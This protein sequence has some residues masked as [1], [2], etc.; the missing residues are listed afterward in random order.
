MEQNQQYLYEYKDGKRVRNIGFMKID[1][2]M[3]QSTIRIYARPLDEVKGIL[4]QRPDGEIYLGA[5]EEGVLGIEPSATPTKI[6]A[7]P[8]LP[9][10]TEE[11]RVPKTSVPTPAQPNA[12]ED[13]AT[14]EEYIPPSNITY[15][16]IK[17]QDLS[18]LPRKEWR[19]AN[20]SFLLHGF[21]NYHHLLYIEEDGHVWIGVP[22]I[23][24]EKEKQAANM[25]GFTDFRR[26]VD[27]EVD[28]AENEK[29][30]YE[31]FGYWCRQISKS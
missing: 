25:F 31:D 8:E 27:V 4:L 28:L 6:S 15:E 3:D 30:N 22:G 19:L 7:E 23:Y 14:I 13:V 18:R 21:Y 10:V 29:D 5:W 1:S 12:S 26:Q 11:T 9:E 2:Q 16:K 20:N 24:H 17:R